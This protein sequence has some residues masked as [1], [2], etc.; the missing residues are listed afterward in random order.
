[1]TEPSLH[2]SKH[3]GEKV[4]ITALIQWPLPSPGA[5]ATIC[6]RHSLPA[7]F[8]ME[9]AFV[10]TDFAAA[11]RQKVKDTNFEQQFILQLV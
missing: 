1:M 4:K 5:A 9:S 7:P 2:E 10:L 8:P 3:T 11:S 6:Q